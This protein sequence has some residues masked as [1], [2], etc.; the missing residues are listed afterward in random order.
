MKENQKVMA[1]VTVKD[2]DEME[3]AYAELTLAVHRHR[4]KYPESEFEIYLRQSLE[5]S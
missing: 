3:H 1:S 5:K 2:D 4:E